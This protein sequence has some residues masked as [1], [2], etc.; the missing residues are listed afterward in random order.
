MEVYGVALRTTEPEIEPG[1][2][3]APDIK[4]G[5]LFD[6]NWELLSPILPMTVLGGAVKI[7]FLHRV[8]FETFKNL[9]RLTTQWADVV[10]AAINDMQREAEHRMQDLV[11]TVDRL[12][13][14]STAR[15]PDIRSDLQRTRQAQSNLQR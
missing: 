9:S 15:A 3:K 4:V 12:T 7:R 2:P 10:T 13:A 6:H 1:S 5:H 11:E 8:E 14:A